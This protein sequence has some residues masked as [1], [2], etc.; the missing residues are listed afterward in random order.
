MV[1]SS[2]ALFLLGETEAHRGGMAALSYPCSLSSPPCSCPEPDFPWAPFPGFP[3]GCLGLWEER[4]C[5]GGRVTPTVHPH[6]GLEGRVPSRVTLSPFTAPWLY[7]LGLPQPGRESPT[8]VTLPS[9]ETQ[10][11]SFSSVPVMNLSSPQ[12]LT[13]PASLSKPTLQLMFP[14]GFQ[15]IG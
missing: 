1:T 11:S 2:K 3:D 10:S 6:L 13:G 7:M 9:P 14:E 4:A 15:P 8:F 5:G 12:H